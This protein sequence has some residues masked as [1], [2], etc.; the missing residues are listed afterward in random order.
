MYLSVVKKTEK[1]D[2][3]GNDLVTQYVAY[4]KNQLGLIQFIRTELIE[5][6]LKE[7]TSGNSSDLRDALHKLLEK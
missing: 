3:L 7:D 1:M 4:N 5:K 2:P 6:A